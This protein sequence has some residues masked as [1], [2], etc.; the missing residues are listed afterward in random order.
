MNP[1]APQKSARY[2]TRMC[3]R[4]HESDPKGWLRTESLLDYFQD[5]ASEHAEKLGAG[6]TDLMRLNLTWVLSRYHVRIIR[7]PIWRESLKLI[8][9]PSLNF[10]LFALREFEIRDKNGEIL[11]A[12][13]SSWMLIDLETKRPVPPAERFG[14]YPMDQSRA[15][16][17]DFE[18]LPALR[19]ADYEKPFEVRMRDL[20]WNRHV[21]HVSYIAWCLET[22]SPDFRE[23]LRPSEI[24]ADFRGQAF[25]GDHVVCRVRKVSISKTPVC[26]YQI[27]KSKNGKELA[28]L[29]IAW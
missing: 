2:V 26:V 8:T 21:N 24:E 3:V 4:M 10:G 15:I 9:W 19:D 12:A 25:L 5:A 13:T 18:P 16:P 14:R 22:A 17:S 20:D 1:R 7:Y 11:A 28:R 23:R 27:I 6:A 29:R